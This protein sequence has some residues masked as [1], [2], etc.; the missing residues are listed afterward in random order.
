[1]T[2]NELN[3]RYFNWMCQL[4]C[5]GQVSKKLT[6]SKL[7]RRL[8]ETTFDYSIDMDGNRASDGI[9]LRYRF[10]Y[11]NGYEGA[12]IAD[13]LDNKPCSILEMMVALALRCEENI[14]DDPDIG[15]RTEQW[16]WDMVENLRLAGMTNGRF[17][18]SDTDY[19]LERFINREYDRYGG[20]G[21]FTVRH[22][23][24][25]MRG[26]EIWTQMCWYLNEFLH[27]ERE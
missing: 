17:D 11:E 8:H 18:V 20:G 19:I 1:M 27:R 13:Y 7:L 10:G 9:E 4:V 24:S 23:Q 5:N 21:L 12:M 14:M 2:E 15:N 6:Y 16:F 3:K 26:V 22:P 25:D